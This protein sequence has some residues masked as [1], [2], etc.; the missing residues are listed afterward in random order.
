LYKKA[1]P[2]WS[3]AQDKL[4]KLLGDQTVAAIQLAVERVRQLE[5]MK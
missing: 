1:A 5:S 3:A 4:F 2:A